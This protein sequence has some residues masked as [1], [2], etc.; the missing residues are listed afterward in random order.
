M[1]LQELL[2]AKG[3]DLERTKLIRHNLS[4]DEVSAY[5]EK[6]YIEL[7]QRIQRPSR[8][9]NCDY[10]VSFLGEESTFGTFLGCYKVNGY[11]DYDP[12]LIPKDISIAVESDAIYNLERTD[13]LADL[14]HRLI[15]DW[16]KGTIN[17]CQNGTTVKE[18][19]EI[20]RRQGDISFTD[21]DHVLLTW[22]E[23]HEI[24]LNK[25]SYKVWENK[26]SAVAGVYLITDT[27]TGKHYI[28][29]ASGMDSGGIWGRWS[30]YAKTKHG[31]NKQLVALIASDPD[32]CRHFQYSILEVL[33]LKQD[34]HDVLAKEQLYKRKLQSIRFGLND[35]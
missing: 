22:D 29:S 27:F 33:P 12:T 4:S 25:A 5:Y 21:Y 1:T 24:V 2:T 31:G 32:Y 3:I 14:R 19:V 35:N 13:I 7:Y 17:W 16:G 26:L 11:V 30:E 34:K 18:V 6:G 9:K 15:I 10:V 28:G 8:F 23:L 20:R